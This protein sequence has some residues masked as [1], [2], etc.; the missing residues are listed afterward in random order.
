MQT[1]LEWLNE[2]ASTNPNGLNMFNDPALAKLS[3]MLAPYKKGNQED[4]MV[5]DAFEEAMLHQ[6]AL[7]FRSNNPQAQKTNEFYLWLFRECRKSLSRARKASFLGQRLSAQ[8]QNQYQA[9]QQMFLM[10][11]GEPITLDELD[12][13]LDNILKTMERIAPKRR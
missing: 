9:V 4:L 6:I 2:I 5:L 1:F 10:P 8:Q 12:I 7:N 3:Q 11:D 13:T